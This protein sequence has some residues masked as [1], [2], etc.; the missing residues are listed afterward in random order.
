MKYKCGSHLIPAIS[1]DLA[2]A[3]VGTFNGLAEGATVG[4]GF[5]ISYHGGDGNDVVLN[6]PTAVPEPST[7]FIGSLIAASLL[8]SQ[9]RRL[10]KLKTETL[11][12]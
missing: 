4:S 9:R 1:N 7:W 8:V 2:D 11:K 12:S 10:E 5:T 3:V 6:G